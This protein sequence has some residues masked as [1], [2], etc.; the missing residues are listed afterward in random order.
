[1]N[2]RLIVLCFHQ[3]LPAADPFRA[4]AETAANF[5]RLCRCIA[6]FF[7]PLS[8]PDACRRLADGGSL[9]ARAICITLDDGYADNREVAAPILA[10]TGVPATLFVASGY[11]D[12]KV[13]FNDAII[14]ALRTTRRDGIDL[15]DLGI[16]LEGRRALHD[17]SAR[18]EVIRE[19]IP[20]FKRRPLA[21]RDALVQRLETLLA[22]PA[23]RDLMMTPAAVREVADMGFEIGGHTVNHPIL[24]AIPPTQAREEIA[25]GRHDLEAIIQREVRSFAY[26]NGRA[27]EDYAPEHVD[28]VRES[29]FDQAVT[30]NLGSAR[31]EDDRYQL[32]R[33]G[34]WDTRALT[35]VPRMLS[36]YFRR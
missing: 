5:E 12:G 2:N 35:F 3:V 11:L 28:I 8:L 14:E 26:P 31:P 24:T 13:M 15:A 9:P 10:R 1:M 20:V 7:R 25:R 29:G 4:G 30:T 16:E 23:A 6:R 19:L 33:R 27:G 34:T 36:Y 18:L 21:E 22:V 17:L 32:P